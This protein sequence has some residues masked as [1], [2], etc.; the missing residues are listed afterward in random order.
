MFTQS[1]TFQ[2]GGTSVDL[3][4]VE[5]TLVVGLS[6]FS[7]LFVKLVP[8]AN[9]S[10]LALFYTSLL[11]V[12]DLDFLKA[13]RDLLLMCP[14]YPA[15]LG[16]SV[17]F[18]RKLSEMPF[19][20]DDE[21]DVNALRA[22]AE[23][24]WERRRSS[25][26]AR[27]TLDNNQF[28]AY[29]ESGLL[30][31]VVSMPPV[32][33]GPFV[34]KPPPIDLPTIVIHSP[35]SSH[36]SMSSASVYSEPPSPVDSTFAGN[37]SSRYTPPV[38]PSSIISISQTVKVALEIASHVTTLLSLRFTS[39]VPTYLPLRLAGLNEIQAAQFYLWLQE[40]YGYQHDITAIFEEGVSAEVI[41]FQIT[42]YFI[43]ELNVIVIAD[44]F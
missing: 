35:D 36:K 23:E 44:V 26:K 42:G 38:R 22:I 27:V 33:M 19:D 6:S 34:L 3:T 28:T 4:T 2:V 5:S 12:E 11:A 15:A 17:S 39:A 31:R 20:E 1:E 24:R 18:A 21:I 25:R 41:A 9:G 8:S 37:N 43:F 13:V 32:P 7:L 30:N 16:P 14:S 10:K 29:P 40:R